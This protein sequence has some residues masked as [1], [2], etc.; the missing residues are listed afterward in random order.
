MTPTTVP[1]SSHPSAGRGGLPEDLG[2]LLVGG[3]TRQPARPP[4]P[5]TDVQVQRGDQHS[6]RQ[7]ITLKILTRLVRLRKYMDEL[8]KRVTLVEDCGYV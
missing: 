1:F 3:I 2:G 6:P 5:P 7:T 4:D 8:P